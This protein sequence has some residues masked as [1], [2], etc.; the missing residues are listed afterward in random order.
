M[1][2]LTSYLL[3]SGGRGAP[4]IPHMIGDVHAPKLKFLFTAEFGFRSMSASRGNKDLLVIEYDLKSAGRPNISVNQ[5][6]VNYYGYRTKVGTRINFGT[7]RLT[8][9]EDSLNTASDLLW[10]YMR[11]VSPL[12]DGVGDSTVTT[13][14]DEVQ[15]NGIGN[16]TIGPLASGSEDGP[17][18]WMKVHHHYLQDQDSNKVTTYHCINPKIESIELDELDMSS[19]DAS[20]ITIVFTIE[21]VTVSE[22]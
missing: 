7:I 17:I 4:R 15:A 20:S 13:T 21:G 6:D 12:T 2:T 18:K 19:S 3:S 9:Y 16:T 14:N 22:G 10:N 11:T 1:S 5:E 8:F